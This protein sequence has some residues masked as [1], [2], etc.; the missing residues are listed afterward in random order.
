MTVLGLH[1]LE[2]GLDLCVTCMIAYNAMPTPPALVM[3]S[4]TSLIVP[5]VVPG[6]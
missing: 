6:L 3:E 5:G 1:S 4:A 2:E